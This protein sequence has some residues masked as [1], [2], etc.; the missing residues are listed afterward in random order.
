MTESSG[1]EER[2]NVPW[3]KIFCKGLYMRASTVTLEIKIVILRWMAVK[4]CLAVLECHLV[5]IMENT[6]CF[7]APAFRG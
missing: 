2:A 3:I 1:T 6:H 7:N 4:T 5:F